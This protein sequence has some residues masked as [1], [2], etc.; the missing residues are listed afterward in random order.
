MWDKLGKIR[1]AVTDK[2][3][4]MPFEHRNIG[5]ASCSGD[6]IRDLLRV[7]EKINKILDDRIRVHQEH[8]DQ[9]HRVETEEEK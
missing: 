9:W 5:S 3:N 8:L 1:R 7:K 2:F 6:C 4:A